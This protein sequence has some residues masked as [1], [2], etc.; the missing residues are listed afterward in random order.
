MFTYLC[1]LLLGSI[2][3]FSEPIIVPSEIGSPDC[4][5]VFPQSRGGDAPFPTE[6]SFRKL[7][8]HEVSCT[9]GSFDP[10][11]VKLGDI[12]YVLDWYISWF[13][14]NIHPKIAYPYVLITC[15][16][17]DFHPS[18]YDKMILYDPKICAWFCKNLVLSNHPKCTTLPYG[19]GIAQSR[20][21]KEDIAFYFECAALPKIDF[22]LV[23]MNF[24]PENHYTRYYIKDLFLPKSFCFTPPDYISRRAYHQNQAR[25]KFVIAPRGQAIDTTRFWEAVGVGTIPIYEHSPLDHL[26]AGTPSLCIHDWEEVT[27][28]LLRTKYD[29][30]Q[31][32]IKTG[33][34]T[35]EKAFLPYWEEKIKTT[36]AL[37]RNGEWNNGTLEATQ[38]SESEFT[39]IKM[40]LLHNQGTWKWGRSMLCVYGH[41]LSLKALQ[42]SDG[43]QEFEKIYFADEF[44][45]ADE[46]LSDPPYHG[47]PRQA[48]LLSSF[49]QKPRYFDGRLE[50]VSEHTFASIIQRRQTT[51]A[52]FMDLSHYC[53]NFTDKL[54]EFAQFF[55]KRSLFCGNRAGDP[56]VQELLRAFSMKRR[57]VIYEFGNLWYFYL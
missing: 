2:L 15:D 17:D 29:E 12:V 3:L 35:Q 25:H 37:I 52:L 50:F 48:A 34:L 57:Q 49:A 26:Y 42:L 46:E 28:E 20:Y 33:E 55:P 22:P 21:T 38:F 4:V 11:K 16:S 41:C 8:D 19:Q 32:K 18:P 36:Q 47:R 31:T 51:A 27:E 5:D 43:L 45:F 40:L 13:L 6:M 14:K 53:Y 23:Y 7:A 10:E 39:T 54:V 30:I 1:G 44:A 9:C 56:Y 24:N